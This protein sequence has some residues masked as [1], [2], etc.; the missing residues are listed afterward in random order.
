VILKCVGI[1]AYR[2]ARGLQERHKRSA[3]LKARG[4]NNLACASTFRLRC[5]RWSRRQTD[6]VVRC[7]CALCC[8]PVLRSLKV[9]P[10]TSYR[11]PIHSLP[12]RVSKRLHRRLTLPEPVEVSDPIRANPISSSPWLICLRSGKSEESKRL[13]YSAFFTDKYVSSRYSAIV[14]H[15]G[16]QVYHPLKDIRVPKRYYRA[17]I[18]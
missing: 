11:L 7:C 16:E 1:A 2:S 3:G 14:D 18:A 4:N 12:L 17:V 8:Q 9:Y 13:T 6:A 5:C 10:R 15:C